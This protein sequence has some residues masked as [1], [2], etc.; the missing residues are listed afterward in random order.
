MKQRQECKEWFL[1]H[2]IP[3]QKLNTVE[4]RLGKRILNQHV[5]A[6]LER[7]K[8]KFLRVGRIREVNFF[9]GNN[10]VIALK[11]P[12]WGCL[13]SSEEN[14]VPAFHSTPRE[15]AYKNAGQIKTKEQ[16][17][18]KEN[19]QVFKTKKSDSQRKVGCKRW[20]GKRRV[21]VGGCCF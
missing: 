8:K 6:T 7:L 15:T 9:Y 13:Q 12:W 5:R 2:N 10:R 17:L 3:S 19:L 14:E 1:Q 16:I 18:A 20:K 11:E 21:Y 4:A